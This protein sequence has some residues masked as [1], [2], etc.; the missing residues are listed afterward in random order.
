M[1]VN[2]KIFFVIIA[3]I[4]IGTLASYSF[5]L[6]EITLHVFDTIHASTEIIHNSYA[7]AVK[8]HSFHNVFHM[9]N[10]GDSMPHF[11]SNVIIL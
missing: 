8:H 10:F 5:L 9:N 6:D 11:P 3:S 4:I 1:E 7:L 2:E